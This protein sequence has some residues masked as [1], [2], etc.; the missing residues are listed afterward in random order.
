MGYYAH[1]TF[2]SK[3]INP[4]QCVFRTGSEDSAA[5][6]N[7]VLNISQSNLESIIDQVNHMRSVHYSEISN[8]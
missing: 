5:F 3:V 4:I 1:I 8:G 2:L 6:K 7:L